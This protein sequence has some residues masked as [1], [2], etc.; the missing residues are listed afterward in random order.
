[1][2]F[3]LNDPPFAGHTGRGVVVAVLDS[4]IHASHP[5]VGT[6]QGGESFAGVSDGD[7]DDRI[8][9]GTAVA[10]AIREKSPG[11]DLLAVKVF[12]TQLATSVDVLARAIEWAAD[13]GARII[14][15]SLGTANAAHASRLAAAADFAAERGALIV[16]A[17]EGNQIDWFPGSLAGVAGVVADA[18]CDRDSVEVMPGRDLIPG[19][20]ASPFP[21]PIPGVPRER[22]LS[23]VSFAVANVTGFLAR[24]MEG[25]GRGAAWQTVVTACRAEHPRQK[26]RRLDLH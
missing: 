2:R 15:L 12:D 11:A 23:G 13:Q 26:G 9:H 22:N 4:G 14:N 10:A 18:A 20:R 25:A 7:C 1:M 24:A 6:V 17:R 3:T 19:F 16:S 21:R 8:G 5:H